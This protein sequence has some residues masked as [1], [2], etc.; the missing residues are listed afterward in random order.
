MVRERG[1]NNSTINNNI[2]SVTM[3]LR[4]KGIITLIIIILIFDGIQHVF[5]KV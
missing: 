1:V 3:M 5:Y 4:T 2:N